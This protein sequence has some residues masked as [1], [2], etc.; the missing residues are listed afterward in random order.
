MNF[1]LEG[2]ETLT[3]DIGRTEAREERLEWGEGREV[4]RILTLAAV[5][6][7]TDEAGLAEHAEMSAG[8]WPAHVERV[9]DRPGIPRSFVQHGKD[10]TPD[11]IG[12]GLG[13][14]VHGE[15]T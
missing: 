6:G 9:R 4:E 11:R 15:N 8:G 3:P 10:L 12:E 2:I 1:C 14:G 13:D 7:V 5:D